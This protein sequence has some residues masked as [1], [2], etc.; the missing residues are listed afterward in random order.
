MG[1]KI[2]AVS[3]RTGLSRS[4]LR[5]WEDEYGLLHP[6]RSPRGTREYSTA[7]IERAL[8]IRELVR[9][10]GLSLHG[11]AVRL[12]ERQM[13]DA[14]KTLKNG[15]DIS[16]I[17]TILTRIASA[18]DLADAGGSLV[19]GLRQLTG[20]DRTELRIF[21]CRHGGEGSSLFVSQASQ[22][23]QAGASRALIPFPV[24]AGKRRIGSISVESK[25]SESETQSIQRLSKLVADLAGPTLA[26][27]LL[28]GASLNYQW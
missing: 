16:E 2:G 4:T 22:A 26:Y 18:D 13:A 9:H 7:D 24:F 25:A 17:H 28:L 23:V 21:S 6:A 5:L 27:F 12:D 20:A 19:E 1:Y 14:D 10:E 15:R 11:V 3:S 8:Y